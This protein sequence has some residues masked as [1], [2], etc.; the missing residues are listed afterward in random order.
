M[1]NISYDQAISLFKNYNARLID[2]QLSE[3]YYK[4]HLEGSINIPVEQINNLARFYLRNKYDLII[5]YCLKGMR[6]V[7]AADML[8]RLGY[9]NIYNIQGGI[10]Y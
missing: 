10:E 7:A 4:K 1:K 9:V 3:D 2:T 8:E 5:V 6:S